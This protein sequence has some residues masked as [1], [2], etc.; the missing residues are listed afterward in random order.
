MQLLKAYVVPQAR[1]QPVSSAFVDGPCSCSRR[2]GVTSPHTV[3]CCLLLPWFPCNAWAFRFAGGALAAQR[4]ARPSAVW[5]PQPPAAI[6][7]GAA[8]QQHTARREPA[9]FYAAGLT[10]G[11]AAGSA[12]DLSAVQLGP[13]SLVLLAGAV[14]RAKLQAELRAVQLQA[15]AGVLQG[16]PCLQ[17]HCDV[18]D[19]AGDNND[20]SLPE[21]TQ[22][23]QEQLAGGAAATEDAAHC[24]CLSAAADGGAAAA[25]FCSSSSTIGC[26]AP[27]I[28]GAVGCADDEPSSSSDGDLCG[29]C[30]DAA[31]AVSLGPCSH[32]LCV[33]CCTSMLGADNRSVLVCPFCRASVGALAP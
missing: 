15:A 23:L 5:G 16:Q 30:M 19:A 24:D 32:R 12:V 4:Y 17:D 2:M 20:A 31:P 27:V 11:A 10:F 9:A 33:G 25:A 18:S 7:A 8:P 29:V 22:H 13:S 1:Q 26:V 6:P 3:L 21:S 28:F 14:L